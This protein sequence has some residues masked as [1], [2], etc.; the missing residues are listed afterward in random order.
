MRCAARCRAS[1]C[2]IP[3][4]I[5]F[6]VTPLNE[7][8]QRERR[9][10]ALDRRPGHDGDPRRARRKG[11]RQVVGQLRVRRRSFAGVPQDEGI[12]DVEDRLVA[13]LLHAGEHLGDVN[14]REPQL[15]A[16]G[17]FSSRD[18]QAAGS[19]RRAR[20]HAVV[21]RRRRNRR[22]IAVGDTNP[23][24]EIATLPDAHRSGSADQLRRGVRL[25]PDAGEAAIGDARSGGGQRG[26]AIVSVGVPCENADVS[27]SDTCFAIRLSWPG[28]ST[29]LTTLNSS[30]FPSQFA[31]IGLV[32]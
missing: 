6:A 32:E 31:H 13:E 10:P 12:A 17:G 9:V 18:G 22:G 19:G 4:S 2:R 29:K 23:E 26:A 21:L 3:A 14:A 15:H 27:E 5:D 30:L 1:S 28:E 24:H 16:G 8:R 7:R 11:C 25:R 20:R